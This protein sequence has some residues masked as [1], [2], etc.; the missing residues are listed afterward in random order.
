[1]SETLS[2]YLHTP[3]C[4]SKCPYCDFFSGRGSAAE[5]DAY[6][7]QLQEKICDWAG[8]TGKAAATV[9]FGGGT[10][11]VLGTER[12]CAILMT[13]KDSF[14]V[15]NDA[16]ITLEVN[17]ESGKSLDFFAL[18]R[19]GFNRLSVGLQSADEAELEQLGRIHSPEDVRLTVMNAQAAGFGNISLDLML[20]I[21]L[22]TKDSLRRSIE[23][24]AALGVQ[25][26]SSYLLKIERGTPFAER[27]S[28]PALPDEDEQGDLYL[29]AVETLAQAGYAQYEV[30]NFAKPGFES[31]HNSAYWQLKDYIG[32]GPS[33]HSFYAGKR[34]YYPRSMEAF[35]RNQVI[36][37]GAGGDEEEYIMLSL[38]LTSGLQYD[39]YEQRYGHPLPSRTMKKIA[40]FEALGYMKTDGSR[41]WLTPEG[42]LISNYI[43]S[44]LM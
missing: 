7:A 12:L 10:P 41:A 6:T 34:F 1:M 20:G 29:F 22:Q 16:E 31:R 28:L 3:F 23:F 15:N 42:F 35:V 36:D 18:R 8:K 17:P 19:A 44:E 43:I 9:Y 27:Q 37:D 30:S 2:L 33:A 40:D 32:V 13:V 24:C 11:S 4:K 39:S 38:R 25:H 26:I 14:S 5:Y 21:P